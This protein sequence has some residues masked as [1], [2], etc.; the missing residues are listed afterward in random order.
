MEVISDNMVKFNIT[1]KFVRCFSYYKEASTNCTDGCGDI[2]GLNTSY[3]S[4]Y[5][6]MFLDYENSELKNILTEEENNKLLASR[7]LQVE[8]NTQGGY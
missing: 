6:N 1:Q 8:Y 7:V 5:P 4:L 2:N 3:I